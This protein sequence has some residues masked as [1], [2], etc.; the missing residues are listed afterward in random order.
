MSEIDPAALDS[1]K[2]GSKTFTFASRFFGAEKARDAALLYHWLRACDDA[3]DDGGGR[4]AA[5]KIRNDVLLALQSRAPEGPSR[6]FAYVARKHAIPAHY[7]LEFVEGMA[8]DVEFRPPNDM[9]ELELYCYRV[10]GVVGLMMAHVMGI[11]SE[12]ALRNAC[13][14]GIAMQL[15]NIARDVMTI[16]KWVAVICPLICSV[17]MVCPWT[18][19]SCQR[20]VSGWRKLWACCWTARTSI[21]FRARREQNFCPSVQAL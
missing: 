21:M 15:T 18:I 10:A 7:P 4:E 8:G 17:G 19:I 1:I 11:S 9:R 3:V 14:L 20:T 6:A 12:K 13:D 16:T 5:L 2:T